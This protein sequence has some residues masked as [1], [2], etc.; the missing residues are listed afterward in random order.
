MQGQQQLGPVSCAG[1]P[2]GQFRPGRARRARQFSRCLLRH[3]GQRKRPRRGRQAFQPLLL[4]RAGQGRKGGMGLRRRQAACEVDLGVAQRA[5]VAAIAPVGGRL[6]RLAGAEQALQVGHQGPGAH[7]QQQVRR[8]GRIPRQ[9]PGPRRLAQLAPGPGQL[10]LRERGQHRLLGRKLRQHLL[11]VFDGGRVIAQVRG[12]HRRLQHADRKRRLPGLLAQ[13]PGQGQRLPGMVQGRPRLAQP[14]VQQGQV[15]VLGDL[16]E[17]ALGALVGLEAGAQQRQR[18]AQAAEVHQGVGAAGVVVEAQAPVVGRQFKLGAGAQGFFGLGPAPDERR[19]DRRQGEAFRQAL[20]VVAGTGGRHDPGRHR[21]RLVEAPQH[22]LRIGL[23]TEQAR[24]LAGRG[25]PGVQH[26]RARQGLGRL[27]GV[28]QA[29]QLLQPSLQRPLGL[30]RRLPATGGL[31]PVPALLAATRHGVGRRGRQLVRL[32]RPRRLAGG[33]PVQRQPGRCGA[34][35]GQPS[36]KV[37][38]RAPWQVELP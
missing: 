6:T 8:A 11:E 35:I 2:L 7:A 20:Q 31:G 24:P 5:R 30:G 29:H 38:N 27:A 3:R 15:V 36:E 33:V 12:P 19:A 22:G 13:L 1:L 34:A 37:H 14:L 21:E 26:R 16:V 23:G 10:H 4:Q 18:V 17:P 25:R 32:R 28:D 9:R